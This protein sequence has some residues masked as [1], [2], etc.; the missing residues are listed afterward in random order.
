V[1]VRGIHVHGGAVER[2]SAPS[3]AAVNLVGVETADLRRGEVLA[4]P[5]VLSVTRRIDAILTLLPDRPLKHG[6]R[7]SVHLGTDETLGVVSIA[8]SRAGPRERWLDAQPGDT[9]IVAPGG[10]QALVRI[11]L[12][13]AMAVRK[14]D[15]FIL[16]A[17]LPAGTV[18]GGVVLDAEPAASG[19]RRG[20]TL[21]RLRRLLTTPVPLDVWL[22]I[23]G[24]EG[25]DAAFL[26]RRGALP[27]SLIA[28]ATDH[29]VGEGSA[30]RAGDRY[31]AAAVAAAVERDILAAVSAYHREHPAEAGPQRESVRA[32]AGRRASLVLVDWTLEQLRGRG[33]LRGEERLA[34]AAHTPSAPERDVHAADVFLSRLAE[35][36]LTP[37]DL[38]T[39]AAAAGVT[40]D[41]AER[42]LS[43]LARER[44]IVR[45]AG[46]PFHPEALSALRRAVQAM[47]GGGSPTL[48][49]ATFKT[50][51]GVSRKFAI[52]LLEWLDRERVTRRV[53]D[54]RIVL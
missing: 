24:A 43:R 37:P 46:L 20:A 40:A 34:L 15:H 27:A 8:A 14:L 13:R 18:A 7:L 12:R 53:G 44:R 50:K 48:D 16:R 49:V 22:E 41:V 1:R 35:A 29:A 38:A 39:L 42:V 4:T 3:R 47:V 54:R 28:L 36:G 6:A 32:H 31:F 33:V 45:L 30:V 26:R 21:D 52:P 2:V 9:G 11:R 10:G 25:I 17:P 23:G 5:G 51:F 19:I